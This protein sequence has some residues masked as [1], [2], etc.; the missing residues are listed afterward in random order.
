MSEVWT[1]EVWAVTPVWADGVWF[2]MGA[3]VAEGEPPAQTSSTGGPD[4]EHYRHQNY[5]RWHEAKKRRELA[6]K[7][8]AE[9]RQVAPKPAETT[10]DVVVV[11]AP[12]AEPLR[13][14]RALPSL[15]SD[16]AVIEVMQS[17]QSAIERAAEL[18]RLQED[19][20]DVVVLLMLH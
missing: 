11:V 10:P 7:K 19:D 2:G 4:D 15:L 18:R 9:A 16:E 5:R 14:D 12:Q 8:R 17:A 1:P 13:L 20:D 6:E 3:A